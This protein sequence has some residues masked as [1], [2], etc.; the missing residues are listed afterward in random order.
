MVLEEGIVLSVE[1]GIY[2]PGKAETVSKIAYKS[3]RRRTL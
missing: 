3:Q 1:P 2:I